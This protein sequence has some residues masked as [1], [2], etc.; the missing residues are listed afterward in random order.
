MYIIISGKVKIGRLSRDGGEDLL[1][2]IG[3]SEM[4]GEM[5]TFDPGPRTSRASTISKVCAVS[6]GRD[7][8][9][10]FM[11]DHPR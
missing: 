1:A 11:F 9:R 5:S 4:F 10:T 7:A 2:V 6:L 8:L 3:P